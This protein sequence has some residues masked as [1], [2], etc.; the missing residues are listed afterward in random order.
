MA[1]SLKQFI[2]FLNLESEQVSDIHFGHAQKIDEIFQLLKETRTVLNLNLPGTNKSFTSNILA[3]DT[4]NRHFVLD[5]I[6]PEEGHK[7][8]ES[9]GTLIAH[10]ELRG[11]RISFTTCRLSSDYAR[12]MS[13]Y[14]CKIPETISYFQRRSEYRVLIHPAHLLH[15][16][17]EHQ[18]TNQIL[19]GHVYDVSLQGIGVVFKTAHIF[20]PGDQMQR[21]R[22]VL[23][24][25]DTVSF[26]LD[27]R[28]IEST[29]PGCI[30]VGGSFKELN[31]RAREI[32]GR[33][34]RQMERVNIK[35]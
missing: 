8:F 6:Y 22:L 15:I 7:L 33:L 2:P 9:S 13:S 26:T 24:S 4:T 31:G 12:H 34:V 16:T 3:V 19:Q 20:K 1:F 30:R 27:V 21:C 18:R 25:N 17:A 29:S 28:H 35:S 10:A 11:T 32:I 23:P 14:N 5:E